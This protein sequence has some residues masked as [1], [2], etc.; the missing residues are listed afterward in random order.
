MNRLSPRATMAVSCTVFLALGLITAALGPA[1]PDF[2]RAAHSG[3]IDHVVRRKPTTVPEQID[4]LST[5]GGRSEATLIRYACAW[6]EG[7]GAGICLRI[8]SPLRVIR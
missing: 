5:G 4:H 6:S 7:A 1:L 3:E 8:D 2:A